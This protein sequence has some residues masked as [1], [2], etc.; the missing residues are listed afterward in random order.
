MAI[1]SE[2]PFE[3]IEIVPDPVEEEGFDFSSEDLT[4]SRLPDGSI[5]FDIR[6]DELPVPFKSFYSNL[7]EDIDE[8]V[9]S[10]LAMRLLEEIKDDKTARSGWEKTVDLMFRY[11]GFE[12][13]E[14]REQPFITA[15]GAY[16]CTLATILIRSIATIMAEL[17]P[18]SGPASAEI[19]GEISDKVEDQGERVKMYLNYYLTKDDKSYYP[20]SECLAAWTVFSGSGFR[21]CY[22]DPVSNKAINRFIKSHDLI[23]NPHTVDLLSANRISQVMWLDRKEVKLREQVGDFVDCNL[24]L[25]SEE[26]DD[27]QN[28]LS[29]RLEKLDGVDSTV[30]E[31]RNLF[32]FY[33]CHVDLVDSDL[34]STSLLSNEEGLPKPYIVTICESTKRIVSIRRNWK[35][36]DPTF[37]KKE[38]FVHYYYLRG[39]GLYGIG[40]AHII[41]SNA[42]VLTS[43]ERQLIDAATLKNF[44]ACIKSKTLRNENND[45]AMGP[46]SVN[47]VD[48]AGQPIASQFMFVPFPEPSAVLASLRLD[49]REQT[50]QLGASAEAS[51]PENSHNTPVGTTIAVLEVANRVQSAV[52]KSFRQSL[53]RELVLLKDNL[54]ETMEPGMP[55][56]F[57]VPGGQKVVMKEDFNDKINIVP[58]ADPNVITSTHRIIR[59]QTI[60]QLAQSAPDIH[61]KYEVYHRMYD[62]MNVDNID[63]ILAP[64]PKPISVDPISENIAM[65]GSKPVFVTMNQDHDSHLIVHIQDSLEKKQTNP[66]QYAMEMEHIQIHKACKYLNKVLKSMNDSIQQFQMQSNMQL[67]AT[68]PMFL[69]QANNQ[70]QMQL[71]QMQQ[72][73]M[74]MQQLSQQDPKML[75]N[76]PEIQNGVAKEDAEEVIKMQQAAAQQPKPLDPNIVMM[77]DIKQHREAAHLKNEIDKMRIE[78]ESFKASM[79][80]ETDKK[81]I[82][83]EKE[84]SHEK[85]QVDLTIEHLKSAQKSHQQHAKGP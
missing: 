81:K 55:Y 83:A 39:F 52:L 59:A 47:E 48:T 8:G 28:P 21:K 63:R 57:A 64:P 58:V 5:E 1:P 51:V 22:I 19:V 60:L 68:Y 77:E 7:A 41:G 78:L 9:L 44:P 18:A 33:E 15:C 67:A 24:P 6:P 35:E 11:L 66:M 13:T 25:I 49:L 38:Y 73:L 56:P 61:N 76:V 75:L 26:D 62:A 46:A 53:G 85:N 65:M 34:S 14:Y 42:I 74:Q 84:M 40:L 37:K 50:M 70:V 45:I 17:W 69:E 23:V 27:D 36:E 72:K 30:T 4:E 32:K 80:F 12:V 82:E 31:N 54:A 10:T 20:D 29:K 43:T 3:D 2:G 16:D 71:M 79:G